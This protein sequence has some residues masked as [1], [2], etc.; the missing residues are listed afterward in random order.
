MKFI[1]PFRNKFV[2]KVSFQEFVQSYPHRNTP[3]IGQTETDGPHVPTLKVITQFW[4]VRKFH[5][6]A[7]A[8]SF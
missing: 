7:D 8:Q 6:I 2:R 1:G 3:K 4:K 5:I